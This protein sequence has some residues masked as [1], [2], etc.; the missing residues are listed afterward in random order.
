MIKQNKYIQKIHE[1]GPNYDDLRP[2]L[3][4]YNDLRPNL[5]VLHKVL[6]LFACFA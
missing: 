5:H 2:N 1:I 3:H 4:V 6:A